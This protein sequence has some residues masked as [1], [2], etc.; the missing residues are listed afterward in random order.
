MIVMHAACLSMHTSNGTTTVVILYILIPVRLFLT[1]L[2]AGHKICEPLEIT[3]TAIAHSK[4]FENLSLQI[5]YSYLIYL[6][7]GIQNIILL[8]LKCVS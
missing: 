5:D 2:H 8:C 7:H 1:I 4:I 6:P 3:I